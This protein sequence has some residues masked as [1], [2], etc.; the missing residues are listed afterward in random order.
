MYY[1]DFTLYSTV[2]DQLLNRLQSAI[3]S[4]IATSPAMSTDRSEPDFPQLR[5]PVGPDADYTPG[6]EVGV[7]MAEF[8]LAPGTRQPMLNHAETLD[9]TAAYQP[10]QTGKLPW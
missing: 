10:A 2:C 3:N 9:H 1:L 7:W 4:L 6:V 5:G 8:D